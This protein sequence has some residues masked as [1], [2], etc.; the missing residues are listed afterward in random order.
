[1]IKRSSCGCGCSD[2][3]CEG[4]QTVETGRRVVIDFLYLDLSTCVRCQGA[5]S[6][7]DE[8]V[9]EVSRLLRATGVE[10]VLNKVNVNTEALAI[11]HRFISS[12]TI[13]VNGRDI[14]LEVKEN[15]CECCSD[16]SGT[17]VDCRT[18]THHGIDYDVPPKAMII[19]GILTAVYGVN[20]APAPEGDYTLPENLRRFYAGVKQKELEQPDTACCSQEADCAWS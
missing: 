1:M 10:V 17:D 18:W 8:A 15:S 19:E 20:T 5:D 3:C 6:N 4:A 16:I 13:R 7:L 9:A 2:G 14:Q 12:P 11:Q